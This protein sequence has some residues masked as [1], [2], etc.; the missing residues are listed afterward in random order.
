VAPESSPTYLFGDLLAL[1]RQSWVRAMAD[2]LQQRGHGDYRRSDAAV[3]RLLRR[4]PLSIGELGEVVGVTRQAARKM[5]AGL[6]QRGYARLER[7]PDDSRRLNVVLT[8][9]GE[10]Y[11]GEI[12]DV[13]EILN[14]ELRERVEPDE[15]LAADTVLRVA[16]GDARERARAGLLVRPP[17]AGDPADA[18]ESG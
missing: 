5:A 4:R 10:A 15:L 17:A 2:R 11:A 8:A 12:S 14:R 16:I 6:Q 7:D 1:A 3:L 18:A 13:I 9:A